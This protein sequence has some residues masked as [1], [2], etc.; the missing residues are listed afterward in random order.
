MHL[1]KSTIGLFI[2]G[3]FFLTSCLEIREQVYIKR[4]GSGTFTLTVD[5]SQMK[6]MMAAMGV[7][8]ED[9]GEEDPF[10]NMET[11]FEDQ[12]AELESIP[13]VTNARVITDREAYA[14]SVAFDFTDI[15][16]LNAGANRVFEDENKNSQIEYYRFSRGT[17]ERTPYWDHAEQV[18]EEMSNSKDMQGMDPSALFGDMN[19][20]TVFEFERPV[21]K[22]DNEDYTR[23]ADNKSVSFQYYF[24]K[25]EYE[26]RNPGVKVSF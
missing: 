14:I 7:N 13:G 4:N 23:S 11:D 3:L 1:P 24:F 8:L 5:M 19:Y 6:S 2:L 18:K 25:E 20:T 21:K 12:K 15:D 17:F 16:A 22:M 26:G 9:M 10:A